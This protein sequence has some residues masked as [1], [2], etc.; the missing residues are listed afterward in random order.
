M[1]RTI[2]TVGVYVEDQEEARRFWVEKIGFEVRTATDM[3][4]GHSWLEVAPRGAETCLVI[5][6]KK[7]AP[8][9]AEMKPS[10]VF[11]CDDIEDFCETLTAKGVAFSKS[12][13]ATNWGKF[14]SFLDLDGNE[15]GLKG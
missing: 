14:A 15:F 13:E 8:D 3:G 4:K 1:I 6:P 12:L 10:I 2:G 11:R 9:W 5:Y 7:L